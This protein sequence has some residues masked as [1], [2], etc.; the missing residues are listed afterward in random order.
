MRYVVSVFVLLLLTGTCSAQNRNGILIGEKSDQ[1]A[2]AEGQKTVD[3][4]LVIPFE[5]KM[6][7]SGIDKDISMKTGM[8]FQQIRNNMRFGLSNELLSKMHGKMNTISLMHMDTGN[9]EE[10][11]RYIYASI[12][13]KYKEIPV[14]QLV[15]VKEIEPGKDAKTI[16]KAKYKFNHLVSNVKEKVNSIGDTEEEEPKQYSGVVNGEVVTSYDRAERYMATSIHNPNL[17]K[18][19][20]LKYGTT[21]F[22]FINQL[23]IEKAANP[24]QKGLATDAYQRK[25]KVH[26]TIFDLDGTEV[27]SGAS[28]SYFS[29]RVNDMNVIVKNHFSA[30][31]ANIAST[32][33]EPE[34]E[35][36]ADKEETKDTR[37]ELEKY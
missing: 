27:S 2:Y 5:P 35:T 37:S 23:D 18:Q 34:K 31:S 36:V 10:E 13:Y 14:E 22:I 32:I 12:G 3:K 11:L 33:L 20:N 21:K 19:L 30:I 4:A 26:Y 15:P 1:E 28:L 7:M 9:V 17:L 24:S 16:D 8:S 6:Y 25:I 29:S